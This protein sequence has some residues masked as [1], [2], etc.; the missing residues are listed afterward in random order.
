MLF[1]LP[2][3]FLLVL[4]G[5]AILAGGWLLSYPLAMLLGILIVAL[6]IISRVE[7][8]RSN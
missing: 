7:S 6:A 3:E 4:V 5:L 8:Y 2:I 1:I